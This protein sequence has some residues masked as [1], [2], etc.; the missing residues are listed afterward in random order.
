MF[1]F[2]CG[3][4]FRNMALNSEGSFTR[5]CL[6][7][8]FDLRE[9]WVWC[10]RPAAHTPGSPRWGPQTDRPVCEQTRQGQTTLLGE[11][12]LHIL[13]PLPPS[14]LLSLT[15]NLFAQQA[16]SAISWKTLS[17]EKIMS[18]MMLSSELS[19]YTALPNCHFLSFAGL[20][21]WISCF[22]LH[23]SVYWFVWF[24]GEWGNKNIVLCLK[25]APN[26]ILNSHFLFLRFAT[27]FS[28][29]LCFVPFSCAKRRGLYE[30]IFSS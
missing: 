2:L 26:K 7:V 25:F 10:I 1:L 30:I 17:S 23:G 28:F 16:V 8:H 5:L 12:S 21:M 4:N 19:A 20:Q 22:C 6:R 14:P 18:F 3:D 15:L 29:S 27:Y 24:T 9:R 13:P 11:I